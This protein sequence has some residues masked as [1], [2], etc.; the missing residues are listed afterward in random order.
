VPKHSGKD[1]QCQQKEQ[2]LGQ[3]ERRYRQAAQ[4]EQRAIQVRD[5]VP[6]QHAG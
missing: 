4:F 1:R 2:T 3:K 5:D 6:T